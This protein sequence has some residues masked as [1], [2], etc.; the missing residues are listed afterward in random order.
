MKEFSIIG[1]GRLGTSLGTALSKAGWTLNFI[2][3]RNPASAR[4]G[5][6]IIGQGKSSV[7]NSKAALGAPVLFICVPDDSIRPVVRGLSGAGGREAWS[8]RTVF[9]TSGLL[10]SQVLS[11][12]RRKGA[13][14]ASVHPV[15]SFPEK[16]GPP[17]LFEDIFWG[18]EGD[19]EA[20]RTAERIIRSLG[21]NTLH[22]AP[23]DK[24]LYHTSCSLASNALIV[25]VN[26]ASDLLKE[27]GLTAEQAKDVLFPLIQ[28]TL[29]NVKNLGLER[30]L[31]GPVSRGDLGTVRRHLEALAGR[32]LLAGV[33]ENLARLALDKSAEEGHAPRR[34]K[35]LMRL[36]EDRRP[37]LPSGRRISRKPSP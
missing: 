33:Y 28:G 11:S 15:Q 24:A 9:H 20:L 1:A 34:F 7:D 19:R 31:S 8:G 35:A 22:L 13:R 12:L 16:N 2:A 4:E 18:V 27:T 29:Q 30:A 26:A 32:P 3:D 21:G 6:R 25:L 23:T 37:L 5:R 14:T 17:L 36:L 10:P